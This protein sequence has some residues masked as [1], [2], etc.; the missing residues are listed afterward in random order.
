MSYRR[1][2][3]GNSVVRGFGYAAGFALFSFVAGAISGAR[4]GQV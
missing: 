4:V 2:S 1:Y 3:L